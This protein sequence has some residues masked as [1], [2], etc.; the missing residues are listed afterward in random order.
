LARPYLKNTHHKKRQGAGLAE[1]LKVKAL[2]SSPSIAKKKKSAAW[3]Q[4]LTPVI[5]ATWEAEIES[6]TDQGQ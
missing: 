6:V 2:H 3:C 5:L 1:W 4:W